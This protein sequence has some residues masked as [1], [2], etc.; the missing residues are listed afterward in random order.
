MKQA[1]GAYV[2]GRRRTWTTSLFNGGEY[3]QTITDAE[4]DFDGADMPVPPYNKY[5][6]HR[7]TNGVFKH[8]EV[9]HDIRAARYAARMLLKSGHDARI[10]HYCYTLASSSVNAVMEYVLQGDLPI[11]EPTRKGRRAVR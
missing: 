9:H 8:H 10:K 2:V 1:Y 6:V 3:R 5:V 7:G 4:D 11:G